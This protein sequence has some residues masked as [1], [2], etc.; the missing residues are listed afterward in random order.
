MKVSVIIPVYNVEAYVGDALQSILDQT[1]R[2]FEIICVN[3]G[4][5]DG[6]WNVVSRFS[7][8]DA[9]IRLYENPSNMGA[10][11]ARNA[12]LEQAKGEYVY[13]LDA[14]DQIVPDTL[15]KL[16]KK[17][18]ESSLDFVVF[19]ARFIYEDRCF[20]ERF[21]TNP[22]VFKG[23]Y[24]D[25]LSGRELFLL[26]MKYW[27]WIPAPP[28]F[29]Y[30]RQFLE[31]HS[32]RFPTGLLHEDEIFTFDVLMQ[33]VRVHV[34]KETLFL[35][36]FRSNSSMT[37]KVTIR[38]VEACLWILQHAAAHPAIR[39]DASLRDAASFYRK[40][41]RRKPG[42]NMR[43]PALKANSSHAGSLLFF[44]SSSRYTQWKPVFPTASTVSFPR[45]LLILN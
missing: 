44:L 36:R 14:D 11:A 30:R 9:R 45:I 19:C 40:K 12:G 34:L 10:A 1:L 4:S 6:S 16:Y 27:D 42:E 3:D 7:H 21:Q 38:N 33:A 43:Q 13:F 8:S 37:G 24:P 31:K 35:R 20:E 25:V 41:S 39:S 17:A 26:W 23:T 18:R 15:E 29:F 28:R 5:T 22:S 2:D 32:L